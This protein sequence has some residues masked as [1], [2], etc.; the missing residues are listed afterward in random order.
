[1]VPDR[2]LPLVVVVAFAAAAAAAPTQLHSR[3]LQAHYTDFHRDDDFRAAISAN[4]TCAEC[5]DVV[6]HLEGC[7]PPPRP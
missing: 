1:M 4:M 6:E 2:A 7:V 5:E 3:A